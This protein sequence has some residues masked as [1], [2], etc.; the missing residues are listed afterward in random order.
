MYRFPKA[1]LI[2][3]LFFWEFD[4]KWLDSHYEEYAQFMK[5][6]FMEFNTTKGLAK[7]TIK[8]ILN[9]K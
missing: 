3:V 8:D 4:K 6:H 1:L 2:K 5:D 7:Y 9:Y